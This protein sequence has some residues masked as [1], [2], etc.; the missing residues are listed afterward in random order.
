MVLSITPMWKAHEITIKTREPQIPSYLGD[1]H[2]KTWLSMRYHT[3][4]GR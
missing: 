3:K 4:D 2:G 1:V